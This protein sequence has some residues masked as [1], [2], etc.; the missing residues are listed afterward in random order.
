[1]K[2]VEDETPNLKDALRRRVGKED[3]GVI[4]GHEKIERELNNF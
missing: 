2:M 3:V 1:M 4:S